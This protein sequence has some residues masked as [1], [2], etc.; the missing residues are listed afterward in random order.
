[1]CM[2]G[3]SEYLY[4]QDT[5]KDPEAHFDMG[6]LLLLL[7]TCTLPKKGKKERRKGIDLHKNST[8]LLFAILPAVP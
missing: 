1:M 6:H 3:S 8:R 7:P 2:G 5:P 4:F